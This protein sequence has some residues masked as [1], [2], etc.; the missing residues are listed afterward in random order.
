[1][2]YKGTI[3]LVGKFRIRHIRDGKVLSEEEIRNTITTV[4]KAEVAGLINEVTSIGFKWIELGSSSTAATSANTALAVAITSPSLGRSAATCSRVTTDDTD[5]T[6]Q[7]V[8]TFTS[9]A[10]QTV[11]EAGI[12]DS[13]SGGIL[14]ARQTFGAKNMEDADTLEV[15]YKVDVD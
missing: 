11:R 9:T 8:H 15:T 3:R 5:D 10:T 2:E 12:F 7:L 13:A 1:M 14:L 4:G 6:A